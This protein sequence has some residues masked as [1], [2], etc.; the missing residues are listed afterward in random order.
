[1]RSTVAG[2]DSRTLGIACADSIAN[3]PLAPLMTSLLPSMWTVTPGIGASERAS[4]TVPVAPIDGAGA[5][6]GAG[7]GDGANGT[8]EELPHARTDAKNSTATT[9]CTTVLT[10]AIALGS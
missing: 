8:L 4:M 2:D 10:R 1:M 3:E 9:V 6:A 5:G 7:A